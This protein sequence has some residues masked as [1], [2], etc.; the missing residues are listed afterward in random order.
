MLRRL[1]ERLHEVLPAGQFATMFCATLDFTVRTMEYASAG[2]PPQLY[3]RSSAEP[4]ELLEKPG[5]PLGVMR[6]A[7]FESETVPFEPGGALVLYTDGLTETPRPPHPIFTCGSLRRFLNAS[8]G[9]SAFEISNRITSALFFEP[10]IEMDD[11]L[12][13]IVAKHTG[14]RIDPSSDYEI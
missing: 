10:S 14:E 8:P 1:N 13:L 11:D 9:G 3:R 12:T 7:A 4:F 6:N 5:L 2:A